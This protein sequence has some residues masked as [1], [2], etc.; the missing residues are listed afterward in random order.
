MIDSEKLAFSLIQSILR[1]HGHDLPLEHYRKVVGISQELSELY[2]TETFPGL[3]GKKD[4]YDVFFLRYF[5]ALKAGALE[6]K[7]GLFPLLKEMD[8]RGIKRAVASSNKKDV[9]E[10]SLKC[11]GVFYRMDALVHPGMV[12]KVK[13][14]PDIF[15]KAA[16]I[17][18]AAPGECLVLEDSRSGVEAAFAAGIPV[19]FIPDLDRPSPETLKLCLH[20]FDSLF[21]VL[22]Y[23]QA[24]D[25]RG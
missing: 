18:G 4:V 21:D 1:E 9:I 15:L 11:I 8:K 5:E 23:I 25:I 7:P 3:D 2:F 19:I 22:D 16:Q 6:A 10:T 14:H 17:L 20:Q 13:P 12:D 24:Q